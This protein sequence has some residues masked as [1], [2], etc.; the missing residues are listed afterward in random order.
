M[1]DA[2][3]IAV[4]RKIQLAKFVIFYC[5]LRGIRFILL[6]WSSLSS[7]SPG[8][9]GPIPVWVPL[10]GLFVKRPT[11]RQCWPLH[12]ACED[13]EKLSSW[14]FLCAERF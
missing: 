6:A 4:I 8:V 7:F 13:F 2:Y 9:P 1:S 14:D 10:L 12:R 5:L 3:E 11:T